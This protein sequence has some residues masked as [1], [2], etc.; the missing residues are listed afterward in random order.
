MNLI[1][2][3]SDEYLLDNLKN[4]QLYFNTLKKLNDPF[5]GL[6]RYEIPDSDNSCDYV[7]RPIVMSEL[8]YINTFF[9]VDETKFSVN[10]SD[11][12][13]SIYYI[14]IAVRKQEIYKINL[15][16]ESLIDKYRLE[17][18]FHATKV[19]KEKKPNQDLMFDFCNLIISNKLRCY[20]FKYSK[21]KF[22]EASKAVFQKYNN[23]IL[24]F[25]NPEFQALFYFVQNLIETLYHV[26]Y[27]ESKGLL[28]CDRNIY[29]KNDM[30]CF[31]FESDSTIKRMIFLSRKKIKL[32]ALPD[33]FGFIFRKSKNSFNKV[34]FGD[35]S[36]EKSVLI[37]N[38][39]GC[40]I[41]INK[42]GLFS[43]LDMDK[44]LEPYH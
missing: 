31:D 4:H 13:D 10:D 1:K 6:F 23:E 35:T 37:I 43:F 16:L 8:R 33:Y 24:N 7:N 15:L 36:I 28:F 3:H 18:G 27:F 14:A 39:F 21:S 34:E 38:C 30:E 42:A 17:K 12:E 19:F 32:L 26:N 2:F 29:G 25:N 20:C 44:W 9:F 11:F 22:Y 40:L 41:E 5:E